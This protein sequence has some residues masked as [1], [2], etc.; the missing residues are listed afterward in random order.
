[1]NKNRLYGLAA[2]IGMLAASAAVHADEVMV[3]GMTGMAVA[4]PMEFGAPPRR[5][6]GMLPDITK[7]P[8]PQSALQREAAMRSAATQSM[9]TLARQ[10]AQQMALSPAQREA[11]I[12]S[13]EAAARAQQQRLMSMTPA[14]REAYNRGAVQKATMACTGNIATA[15]AGSSAPSAAPCGQ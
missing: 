7:Q 15:T 8:P 3:T 9:Q 14:Q 11:A 4:P 10:R 5:P 2:A 1:M 6:A 12:Q 13:T